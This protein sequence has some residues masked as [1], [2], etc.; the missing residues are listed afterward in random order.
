[1]FYLIKSNC[2][3]R[4]IL[5]RGWPPQIS[6]PLTS[7]YLNAWA[8]TTSSVSRCRSIRDRSVLKIFEPGDIIPGVDR[9]LSPRIRA[10]GSEP[11]Y[12]GAARSPLLS[13]VLT[14]TAVIITPSGYGELASNSWSER[15]KRL[16]AQQPVDSVEERE[17]MS[18]GDVD[19]TRWEF[20]I[21]KA[22]FYSSFETISQSLSRLDQWI[23]RASDY[24][25]I[26]WEVRMLEP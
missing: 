17:G 22:W 13:P 24:E 25:A 7:R 9:T 14:E 6:L 16:V 12:P 2:L 18:R 21:F 10:T 26:C 11:C 23:G 19:E 8:I 20:V 5:V 15:R 4:F 3:Q 1:M